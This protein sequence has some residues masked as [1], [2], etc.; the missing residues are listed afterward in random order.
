MSREGQDTIYQMV[1]DTVIAALEA[2]TVPWEQGWTAR[3]YLPTSM[4]TNKPYRGI[5][6]F[7]LNMRGYG[8]PWWG[9]FKKIAELGGQ[10]R[11]G[12]KSTTVV[13][14]KRILVKDD[15]AP[16]GVKAIFMLRYYRVF[17]AEQADGLPDKFYPQ[18]EDD[19]TAPD[20]NAQADAII[21][22]YLAN[23][24]PAMVRVAG[25]SAYYE[26]VADKITLPLRSQFLES[27]QL[28]RNAFHESV[29]STGHES[30]LGRIG[31][32]DFDYHGSAQYAMEELVAGMGAAML[33]GVVGINSQYENSAAYIASWLK[34][35]RNDHKLVI[36]AAGLA[37][38]AADLILGTTF[39][40]GDSDA[41]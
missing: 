23:G 21:E 16:D 10:V 3:G 35:L 36:K 27:G 1:T 13:F 37:Q 15:T 32:T 31:I 29:H 40:N 17:N 7:L 11:K 12:E 39:D 33:L 5:N 18:A 4:S 8:S 26:P 24:G 25:D 41:D 28:Y 38:K 6:V 19:G 9:T 22:R 30:R 20:A 2:G 34:A 14:W